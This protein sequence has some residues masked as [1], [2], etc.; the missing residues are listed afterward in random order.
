MTIQTKC[1]RQ[2]DPLLKKLIVDITTAVK[3]DNVRFYW[4]VT[5]TDSLYHQTAIWLRE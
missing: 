4:E 5:Y 3:F 1:K 2:I